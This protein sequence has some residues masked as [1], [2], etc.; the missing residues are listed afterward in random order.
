MKFG[1]VMGIVMMETTIQSATMMVGIVAGIMS[2][3]MSAQNVYAIVEMG[4]PQLQQ[5]VC[6]TQF[7]KY[8][9]G[10]RLISWVDPQY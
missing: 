5:E 10:H 8:L 4:K 2:K 3:Q 6:S 7:D 9:K 1:L